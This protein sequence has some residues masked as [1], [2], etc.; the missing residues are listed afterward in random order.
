M[1]PEKIEEDEIEIEPIELDE[2]ELLA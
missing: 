2:D 1:K